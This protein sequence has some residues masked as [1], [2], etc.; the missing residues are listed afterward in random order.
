MRNRCVLLS[1]YF[2]SFFFFGGCFNE[3][4]RV[5]GFNWLPV[6]FLF[7]LIFFSMFRVAFCLLLFV[8]WCSCSCCCCCCCCCCFIFK[9]SWALGGG[10]R[11]LAPIGMG[12]LV[13][14]S[15]SDALIVWVKNQLSQSMPGF[16][17]ALAVKKKGLALGDNGSFLRKAN[18]VSED[19]SHPI[20]SQT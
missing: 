17:E 6:G 2:Y 1:I 3:T 4:T 7:H 10:L 12:I 20:H 5:P 19:A 16:P 8:C 15:R 9:P 11:V 13:G 18:D 14:Y